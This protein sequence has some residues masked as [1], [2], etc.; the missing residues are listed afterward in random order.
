MASQGP[1]EFYVC[2]VFIDKGINLNF[3]KNKNAFN[4]AVASH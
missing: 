3:F 4:V 2:L 1:L